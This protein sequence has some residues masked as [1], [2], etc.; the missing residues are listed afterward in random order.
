MEQTGIASAVRELPRRLPEYAKV[1]ARAESGSCCAVY[2]L[3]PV[4]R[5]HLAAAIKRFSSPSSMP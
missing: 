3:S 1:L 5:A 2:G 4:H